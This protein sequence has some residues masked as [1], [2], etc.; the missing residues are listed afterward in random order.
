MRC[1]SAFIYKTSFRPAPTARTSQAWPCLQCRSQLAGGMPPGPPGTH[2]SSQFWYTSLIPVFL[3]ISH[4]MAQHSLPR[5]LCL[6]GGYSLFTHIFHIQV[7]SHLSSGVLLSSESS[8]FYLHLH[9]D[10]STRFARPCLARGKP[11][12]PPVH[13]FYSCSGTHVQPLFCY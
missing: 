4:L 13:I 2:A 11:L 3:H 7:F 12:V 9:L 8:I 1:R 6:G 5:V 10:H